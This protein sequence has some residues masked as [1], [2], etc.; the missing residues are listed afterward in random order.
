MYPRLFEIPI[1]HVTIHSFGPMMV[2]GSLVGLLLTRRLVRRVGLDPLIM[3]NAVLYSVII[4]VVGARAFF[5]V[6]HFDEFRGNLPGVFAVWV[7]GLEFL[8]GVIPAIGFLLFYLYH[9]KLPV[10]RYLDILAIGLMMGLAFGRIGCFLNA[11]CFG[12]PTDLAWGIRFPYASFVYIS[13]INPDPARNRYGPHLNLPKAEYFSFYD[14]H[15]KWYPKPLQELSEQ[16]QY[17]V[18]KGRYR[19]LAVHPVQLYSCANALLLCGIL[20]VFWRRNQE[21]TGSADTRRQ[22]ARPGSTVALALVLY[23]FTR[24]LL[25]CVRDDNPYEFAFLTISQILGMVLIVVGVVLLVVLSSPG[26]DSAPDNA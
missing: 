6:H 26:S 13:Q 18:T 3:T 21:P 19:C 4:G 22:L 23:G 5:V 17:E 14:R 2:I 1:I 12:K 16:Q 24:S 10:R 7:G 15:G 11:D 8:G 9:C 25:E 20:Y